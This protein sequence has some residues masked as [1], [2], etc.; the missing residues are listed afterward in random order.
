[1]FIYNLYSI[2]NKFRYAT[3]TNCLVPI[4][5]LSSELILITLRPFDEDKG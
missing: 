2:S 4:T 3:S 1:M 5:H